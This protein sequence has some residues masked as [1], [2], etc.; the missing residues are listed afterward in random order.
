MKS[1]LKGGTIGVLIGLVLGAFNV[2][3][4]NKIGIYTGI[5]YLFEKLNLIGANGII[6]SCTEQL[7]I[8]SLSLVGSIS[9]ILY[10]FVI[11]AIIAWLLG[12]IISRTEN[13][14]GNSESIS[15]IPKT[16]DAILEDKIK[17][18]IEN[19]TEN[20][21]KEVILEDKAEDKPTLYE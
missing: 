20:K 3:L 4:L 13:S 2:V 21:T 11:G 8:N 1:W 14:T 7:C 15:N 19:K 18:E 6:Y 12:A 10:S 17:E 16:E 9:L 5:P